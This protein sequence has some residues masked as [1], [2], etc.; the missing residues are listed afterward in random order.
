VFLWNVG[1][2]RKISKSPH[3]VNSQKNKIDIFNFVR[4]SNLTISGEAPMHRGILDV[5]FL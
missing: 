5:I 4:M 2:H 3:G 1:V